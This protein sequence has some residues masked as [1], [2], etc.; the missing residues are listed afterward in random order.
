MVK[1][2]LIYKRKD[3]TLREIVD[4]VKSALPLA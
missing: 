2:F 4:L 3:A 1:L